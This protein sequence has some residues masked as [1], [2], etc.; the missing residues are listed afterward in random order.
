M[1]PNIWSLS[2]AITWIVTRNEGEVELHPRVTTLICW[3]Q[4]PGCQMA[5][6]KQK[7]HPAIRGLPMVE[8]FR[9][10]RNPEAE[11]L[12]YDRIMTDEREAKEQAV[13]ELWSKLTDGILVGSGKSA[14]SSEWREVTRLEWQELHIGASAAGELGLFQFDPEQALR[15][16]KVRFAKE[17]VRQIWKP[18]INNPTIAAEKRCEEWLIDEM[19]AS[20]TPNKPKS[21]YR[22]DGMRELGV[23][24]AAFDRAWA[25]A[26]K[27]TGA[28]DWSK[29]G[30]KPKMP[31]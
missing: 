25:S 12:S 10:R 7:N 22:A 20:S 17:K 23:S 1:A 28:E 9:K 26:I 11:S 19:R 8:A 15:Y 21:E 27:A 4:D 31:K 2:Q 16:N 3:C 5:R 6:R 18:R 24:G 13:R 29:A 30:P 14:E